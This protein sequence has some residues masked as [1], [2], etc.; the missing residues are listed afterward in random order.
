M[1]KP[2]A[3]TL[4]VRSSLANHT[5]MWR[6]ERPVYTAGL[7]PCQHACPAGEHVQAW[8][9]AAEDGSYESAWRRLVQDNPFPA[10]MGRVCYHP[11]ETAC[12]RAELDS[13]VG[14]NSVERFLGDR[15]IDAGW[16]LPDAAPATGRRVLVVGAGPCGLSAAYQLRRLG[17]EVH[18]H[19]AGEEPGGMMR[20]GIPTFRLPRDVLDIEIAR[21]ADLGVTFCM[22]SKVTDLRETMRAGGFDAALIAIGAQLS[23]RAYLPAG[24][25]SRVLDALS[26]LGS[27]ADGERP[28]LGRAVVVYGGGNTAM[29]AART[30]RRLGADDAEIGRAHV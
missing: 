26:V 28:G 5:G 11:C 20:H 12:N 29:D 25:A 22:N 17:H 24:Q 27:V 13:A 2:F 3:I 7:P 19:D 4:D 23:R 8:L 14:I 15:A 1:N 30:A 18:V 6:S 9:Y 21:L 16:R 10:V